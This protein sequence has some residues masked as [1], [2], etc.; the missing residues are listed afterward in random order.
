M[1]MSTT[2]WIPVDGVEPLRL[3]VINRGEAAVRFMR[4]ARVWSR[5]H[6]RPVELIA[7]YT[8]PDARAPLRADGG[9]RPSRSE[10]L[11][12]PQ[13][14]GRVSRAISMSRGLVK[15]C[16]EMGVDAVWPGWGFLGESAE[17]SEACAEEGIAFIGPSADV[18][19]LLG[20]K[21]RSK[22]FAQEHDVPVSPWSGGAIEGAKEALESAER[23]GYP[24]ILKA[25]AGGGGRG[26]RL[27]R[28][29]S[30]RSPRRS[31][32]ARAEAISAFGDGAIFVEKFVADARH[33]EVQILA[34]THG[35]VWSL[36]T[37]DCS[38]Q[39]RHQKIIEETPAPGL[40]D[41][42]DESICAAGRRMA[43]AC[44]YVGAG[45]AEFLLLPDGETFYF[46]EM[47]ARLQVEHTI[48]EAVY[49]ID[50][51]DAQIDI[52]LGEAIADQP[53]TRRGAAIEARLNAEEPDM[54][55]APA[56]GK[57]HVFDLPGGPG[58]RVDSGFRAG[59][60]VAGAFDSNLAKI[61]AYGRD[62]PEAIARLEQ[63]LRDTRVVIEGGLTN[64]SMVLEILTHED[65][66]QVRHST[67]WLDTYI[68]SR[69]GSLERPFLAQSLIAAGLLEFAAERRAEREDLFAHVHAGPPQSLSAP[70]PSTYRLPHRW[71]PRMGRGR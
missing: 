14:T 36:G 27:V 44:G 31:R 19:R 42:L 46:L 4:T 54:G 37:R 58:V 30:K 50:L 24:V 20:D 55:F 15:R 67:R 22:I 61:I 60:V 21:V 65:F 18:M 56:G 29:A 2:R 70:A 13:R 47:N 23:I 43:R 39:R 71:R 41:A 62:R 64:R 3:A 53:P 66:N 26:I 32:G 33:V 57:I 25:A 5:R 68:T 10:T 1:N 63:A 52:A 38:V 7:F 8:D 6:D 59:D 11:F 9:I 69:S 48:S 17:L 34:D 51:V 45:T 28:R 16:V 40:S 49:G 35:T 12:A